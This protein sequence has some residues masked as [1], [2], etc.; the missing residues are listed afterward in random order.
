MLVGSTP[1][2]LLWPAA[3]V[4]WG[5]GDL[6]SE[7]KHHCFHLLMTTTGTLRIRAGATRD[8]SRHGAA[9][10]RPDVPHAVDARNR[11]VLIAFVGPESQLGAALSTQAKDAITAVP[12]PVVM[13]WRAALVRD[14]GM[15]AQAVE[16]WLRGEILKGGRVPPIHPGVRRVLEHLRREPG[17]RAA[18]SLARLAEIAGMSTSHFTH[19]FTAS[20]GVALR[21]YILWLRLQRAS[22]AL[23]GGAGLTEAAH[24][25]G[26]SDAAHMTRTFRRMLGTAPREL[27]RLRQPEGA[28]LLS[29]QP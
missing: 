9:L 11:T 20:V 22:G 25:A 27:I 7:H 24:H 3:M 13:R 26:F 8:W 15:D 5:P 23:T 2:A 19:T 12:I 6:S 4:V 17:D 10:V 29:D 16:A 14:C 18:V 28:V 1:G 21:P